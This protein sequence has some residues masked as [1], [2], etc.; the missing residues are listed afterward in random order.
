MLTVGVLAAGALLYLR[1]RVVDMDMAERLREAEQERSNL[2]I[3]PDFDL[4]KDR[5]VSV[6]RDHWMQMAAQEEQARWE[7]AALGLVVLVL[8]VALVRELRRKSQEERS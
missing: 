2:V 4:M 1:L 7:G 5:L 6:H 8:A 3:S